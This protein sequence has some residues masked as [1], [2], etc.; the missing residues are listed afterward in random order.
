MI[1]FIR[2]ITGKRFFDAQLPKLITALERIADA[3]EKQNK[4]E[5][6]CEW[7]FKGVDNGWKPGCKSYSMGIHEIVGFNSGVCPYCGKKMKFK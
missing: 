2:T 6:V 1:E 4:E 5:Q 3:L 7:E